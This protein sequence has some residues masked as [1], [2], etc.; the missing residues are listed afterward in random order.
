MIHTFHPYRL[1]GDRRIVATEAE[2]QSIEE[3]HRQAQTA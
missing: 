1:V 2:W 3:L